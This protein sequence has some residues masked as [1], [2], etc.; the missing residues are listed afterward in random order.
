M[1]EFEEEV[2]NSETPNAMAY[3]KSDRLEY[4]AKQ[5]R[6]HCAMVIPHF[7]IFLT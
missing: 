3:V 7:L 4:L 2:I 5:H 1:A 6:G